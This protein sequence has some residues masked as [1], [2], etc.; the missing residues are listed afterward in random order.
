MVTVDAA[1]SASS[2]SKT[3]IVNA[4][5]TRLFDENLCRSFITPKDPNVIELKNKILK[6]KL[7][8]APDWMAMRDWV[9]NNIQYKTDSEIHGIAEFWQFP[10]ETMQLKTG[11]CE[12]FSMLLC[13]L[14]R[15]DGWAPDKAY[16]IVGEKNNQY[17]GWVRV[18]WNGVQY[19][20]EPQGNGFA[21]ALGDVLSL[22]GYTAKYYF[23]DVNFGRFQ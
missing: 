7:P 12:D 14:L 2:A 3:I 5:F 1:C 21:I 18:L 11:D 6:D 17:H 20:I 19:N 9:G 8:G 10:N 22:S 23:N 15:A 16:V 4:N 13:S